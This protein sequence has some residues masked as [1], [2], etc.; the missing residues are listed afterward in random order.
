MGIHHPD[1]S[2]VSQMK[3]D[4]NEDAAITKFHHNLLL[5]RRVF[6]GFRKLLVN[7]IALEKKRFRLV[8]GRVFRRWKKFIEEKNARSSNLGELLTILYNERLRSAYGYIKST[9]AKKE[10]VDTACFRHYQKILNRLRAN[11]VTEEKIQ[12]LES[13][14]QKMLREIS[15]E[16]EK[17]RRL[18]SEKERLVYEI[19]FK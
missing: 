5:I 12:K 15:F 8:S 19:M 2:E 1:K 7:R 3:D 11:Y 13:G 16:E 17:Q 4:L 18:K 14:I 6:I 10:I 9:K